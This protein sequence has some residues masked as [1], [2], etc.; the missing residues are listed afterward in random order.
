M[1]VL[2]RQRA[3]FESVTILVPQ[4]WNTPDAQASVDETMEQAEW[5]VAPSKSCY[6]DNP[7][8]VQVSEVQEGWEENECHP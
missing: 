5:R 3:Y 4:S 2:Y 7:Y 8:T 6:G 1:F